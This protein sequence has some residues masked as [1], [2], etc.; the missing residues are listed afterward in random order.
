M[1]MTNA[2]WF[3]FS[4]TFVIDILIFILILIFIYIFIYIDSCF[5]FIF[6]FLIFFITII[7]MI[8]LIITINIARFTN[9]I[10]LIHYFFC[11]MFN[12]IF[13]TNSVWT[14]FNVNNS[15]ILKICWPLYYIIT[16]I[17]SK[18][19]ITKVFI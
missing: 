3:S 12:N 9:Y 2:F 1:R 11:F 7:T 19:V 15:N 18:W 13:K 8:I 14:F 4:L 16:G 6:T 17:T 5:I 10:K